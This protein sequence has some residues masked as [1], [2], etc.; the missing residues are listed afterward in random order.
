LDVSEDWIKGQ[1]GYKANIEK[2][3]KEEDA[4]KKDDAEK[5]KD[6]QPQN[7]QDKSAKSQDEREGDKDSS[8]DKQDAKQDNQGKNNDQ[9]DKNKDEGYHTHS[10]GE[11]DDSDQEQ[12]DDQEHKMRKQDGSG[13]NKHDDARG[14]SEEDEKK[15]KSGSNEN[16]KYSSKEHALLRMLTE[17]SK[18]M[19]S[20]EMND[21]SAVSPH[22]DNEQ[23]Q[24]IDEE[25]QF[26]P[27]N[28]IARSPD[29]IR[30]TGKHPLNAE[31][32]LSK[33]F[34][35][36]LVTPNQLHYVRNHGA[37]PF[38]QWELHELEIG[39]DTQGE[40]QEVKRFN[41]DDI[42]D[43][44]P[45]INIQVALACDGNRRKE[46]NMIRRSKGFNWGSGA[47]SCAYWKGCLVRDILEASNI[48][49]E[50][51]ANKIWWV[52]FEGADDLQMGK[53]AT[54]IPFEY[55]MDQ[56]NDVILAYEM[57]DQPLPPDHGFP[58]RL[59]IP[60]YVGG[61]CVKWLKRIWI[62]EEES[63]N[64]YHIWDNRVLPEWITEKDGEFAEAAFRHPD[65][66][67]NEQVRLSNIGRF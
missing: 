2:K 29:L 8:N 61:R 57:N 6:N 49:L 40:Y 67:C 41:M 36:G 23:I 59:I 14:H 12:S 54:S 28:W 9:S 19:A 34:S 56:T 32:A 4:K 3:K 35:A 64:H 30:L 21:G 65:T 5:K 31:P 38:L 11:S 52:H 37:V 48:K 15:S 66:A 13:G 50:K 18:Y 20:L 43:K 22:K 47:V 7:D 39:D 1:E 51:N 55:V 33:M 27:D 45:Y 10:G 17:E 44:F 42:R 58:L 24:T 62:S 53:Y 16:S 46:L 26:G 60:G 25:D 63:Q